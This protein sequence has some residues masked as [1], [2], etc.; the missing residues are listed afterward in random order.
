MVRKTVDVTNKANDTKKQQEMESTVANKT[1]YKIWT[2][3]V[4]WSFQLTHKLIDRITF[5][6]C[7]HPVLY[8][9]EKS[10]YHLRY[11]LWEKCCKSTQTCVLSFG[12][13]FLL[14]F[15]ISLCTPCCKIWGRF[16][17]IVLLL[18]CTIYSESW[19]VNC[20][21]MPQLCESLKHQALVQLRSG[22]SI[23]KVG[24]LLGMSQSSVAHLRREISGEIEKQ[25]R[26]RPK[27]LGEQK[28]WLGVHLVIVGRLKTAS[29]VAKQLQEKI[30]KHFSDI[31]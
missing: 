8:M 16:L 19:F 31:T 13:F 20:I 12:C 6:L 9:D 3:I 23:R 5:L 29:A 15:E 11:G 22:V 25:R 17:F 1:E 18:L 27:V 7:I 26:G 21:S 10:H 14:N 4:H 2:L 30:G 28:K 24:D